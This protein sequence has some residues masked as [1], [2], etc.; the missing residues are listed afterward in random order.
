M[1][2]ITFLI[3]YCFTV[4]KAVVTGFLWQDFLHV[5]SFSPVPDFSFLLGPSPDA[6]NNSSFLLLKRKINGT[7]KQ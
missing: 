3:N 2:I 7:L 1:S 4:Q 6:M 5:S